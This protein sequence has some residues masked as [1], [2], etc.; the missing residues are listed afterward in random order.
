[1]AYTKE[2]PTDTNWLVIPDD[3]GVTEYYKNLEKA[4]GKIEEGLK[5]AVNIVQNPGF[6]VDT[7]EE[8]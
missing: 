4:V 5:D 6:G 3:D 2:K 8:R 1:M 7:E